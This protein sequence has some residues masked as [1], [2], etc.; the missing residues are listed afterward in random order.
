MN[1][2]NYIAAEKILGSWIRQC[3]GGTPPSIVPMVPALAKLVD[4]TTA[5]KIW[6][7]LLTPAAS[8]PISTITAADSP[9]VQANS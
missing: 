2:S 1:D 5:Q 3:D 9:A 6:D 4:Q 7:S 8:Q